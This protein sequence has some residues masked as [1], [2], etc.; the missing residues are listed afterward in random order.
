M[1]AATDAPHPACTADAQP[2]TDGKRLRGPERLRGT[3]RSGNGP[4]LGLASAGRAIRPSRTQ[5]RGARPRRRS[6]LALPLSQ[7]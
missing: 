6:A 5:S 4:I 7:R 1:A 3:L 2:A